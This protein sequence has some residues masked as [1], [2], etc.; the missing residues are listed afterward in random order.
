VASQLTIT[1]DL[2][3]LNGFSISNT[4]TINLQGNLDNQNPN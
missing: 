1:G 3:I 4:G 2:V